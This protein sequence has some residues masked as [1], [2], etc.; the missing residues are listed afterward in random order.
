MITSQAGQGGLE[1]N[2]VLTT[3]PPTSNPPLLTE[4]QNFEQ[5][6]LGP[7]QIPGAIVSNNA[8]NGYSTL[9]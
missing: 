4:A 5:T 1:G 6:L 2:V 8:L 7:L 3:T 9:T